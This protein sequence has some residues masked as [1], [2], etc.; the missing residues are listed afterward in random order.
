[1]LII[2]NIFIGLKIDMYKIKLLNNYQQ[3]YDRKIQCISYF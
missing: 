2:V 3:I 1:M